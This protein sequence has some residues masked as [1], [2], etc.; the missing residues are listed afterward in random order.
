VARRQSSTR[1]YGVLIEGDQVL[2]VRASNPRYDPPIWWLPGGGIDFG[3]TPEEALVREFL[4]ETGLEV[5]RPR[6]LGVSADLRR[7]DNG[8]HVHTVRINYLVERVGGE[9]AHEVGGTT[10]QARW[11]A[12]AELDAL[13]LAGFVAPA[14]ALAQGAK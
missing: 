6:L 5:A 12:L 2:L 9:L 1:A 14:L 8:D 3:E 10:D 11:F 4:E 13:R 7:R